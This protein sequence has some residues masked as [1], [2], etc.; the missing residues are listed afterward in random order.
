MFFKDGATTAI[1][2][3]TDAATEPEDKTSTT[4]SQDGSKFK[5][6]LR[7]EKPR[8]RNYG[9]LFLYKIS[10]HLEVETH[11]AIL[12]AKSLSTM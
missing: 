4:G 5:D 8:W 3:A 1:S 7:E 10:E 2:K 12:V 6:S 9:R 11:G